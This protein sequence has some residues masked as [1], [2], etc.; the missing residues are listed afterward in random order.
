MRSRLSQAQ[1]QLFW[2]LGSGNISKGLSCQAQRSRSLNRFMRN[3]T[4]KL[5]SHQEK[6]ESCCRWGKI[7]IATDFL[8]PPEDRAQVVSLRIYGQHQEVAKISKILIFVNKEIAEYVPLSALRQNFWN[9]KYIQTSIT[10]RN[11]HPL[12]KSVPR[13]LRSIEIGG[14]IRPPAGFWRLHKERLSGNSG[15]WSFPVER[16]QRCG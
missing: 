1:A 7:I 13:R 3:R 12:S 9:E 5:E 14:Q 16:R 4:T 15:D 11:L 8:N 2:F 10:Y 6:C